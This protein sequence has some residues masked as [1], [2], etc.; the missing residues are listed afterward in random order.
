MTLDSLALFWGSA[1]V[2]LAP[3]ICFFFQITFPKSQLI[4]IFVTAAFFYLLSCLGASIFWYIM[5]PLLGLDN[6]WT[7]LVPGVL[8]Q[9]LAR[10]G[11]VG[12]YHR[13][14][15]VIEVSIERSEAENRENSR[16]QSTAD[17]SAAK[18][19]LELNDVASG[20]AAGTGFGGMHCL[21]MFGS[22]LASE[23]ADMGVLYQPS[24][25]Y[26]PSLVVSSVNSFVFFF[27][28]LFWM[29]FTFFGMRRRLIFPRG[30]GMLRDMGNN[31]RYFGGYY[32]N[33]RSGGNSALLTVIISHFAAA[34]FTTF[35]LFQYGCV[36]SMS[37]V[38][39]VLVVVAYLYWSGI[40]KIYNPLPN[41]NVRL[42]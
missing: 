10:C 28:D 9:F 23:T 29:L 26:L 15:K 6:A 40:S 34:G 11:F 17:V 30:G 32:G 12:L 3:L 41:S 33:T 14:E 8:A 36:F 31:G 16:P 18:L 35:N 22:L 39:V 21:M 38:P 20:V 37:L 2:G 24:C 13:V 19:K 42:S 5:D 27:L 7:A 1:F 25:P 4:I